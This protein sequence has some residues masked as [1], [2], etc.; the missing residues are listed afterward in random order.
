MPNDVEYYHKSWSVRLFIILKLFNISIFQM[1]FYLF[2]WHRHS[3]FKSKSKKK[4]T[5]QWQLYC[6]DKHLIFFFYVILVLNKTVFLVQFLD[7]DQ[8][9]GVHLGTSEVLTH[10][11]AD[12]SK[13]KSS[14][15]V[16]QTR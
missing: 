14:I 2:I 7:E 5:T 16:Q 3:S 6:N 9:F 10:V 13:E 12:W 15:G 11:K 8:L 4:K 1:I